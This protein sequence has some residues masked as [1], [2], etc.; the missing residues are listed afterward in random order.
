M[1]L[2]QGDERPEPEALEA[3]REGIKRYPNARYAVYQNNDL[4]HPD[5][6][7]LKFLAVGPENTLKEAPQRLPDTRSEINWRYLFAGWVDLSTGEIVEE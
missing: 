1:P 2:I 7:H 6:G 4:G 3:M 5:I